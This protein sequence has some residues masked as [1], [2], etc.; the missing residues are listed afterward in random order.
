MSLSKMRRQITG[1]ISWTHLITSRIDKDF[2]AE[3]EEKAA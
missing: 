2:K 3:D 1:R